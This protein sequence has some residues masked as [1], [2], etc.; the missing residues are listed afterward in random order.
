MFHVIIYPCYYISKLLQ[1]YPLI[2]TCKRVKLLQF[3]QTGAL[4]A[5]TML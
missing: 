5:V 2:V 3:Q 1:L 4:L